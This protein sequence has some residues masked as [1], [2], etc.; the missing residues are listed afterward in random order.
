MLGAPNSVIQGNPTLLNYDQNYFALYA[1]DKIRFGSRLSFNAGLRWE[2]YLP[3][4]ETQKRA[5]HF[6]MAS[7]VAGTKS[8]VYDNAPAGLTSPGDSGFPRAGTN[9][10][11]AN[12]GPRVG[13]VWDVDGNARTVVRAGYGVLY[14][15]PAMQ[16]F[17]R[18]GFGPPW[19]SAL[20]LNNPG[21]CFADPYRD[22]SGG[23]PFPLPSPPPKNAL[24]VSA[25]QYINL[26]L[27][28]KPTYFQQWNLS[29]Q[30]QF[31]PDWLFSLNYIGNK[32]THL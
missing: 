26:P 23:N 1:S 3:E 12:L 10:R 19:A 29:I 9:G 4:I 14:D 32:G 2:P 7:F 31:G 27:H 22:Y 30:Q 24:F 21:G 25:G 28:L 8:Q 18:F 17:D 15:L 16:Y 20:T 6:D 11:W 5:N 13:L